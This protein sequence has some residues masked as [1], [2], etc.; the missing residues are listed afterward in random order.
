LAS[1]SYDSEIPGH[2]GAAMTLRT[3]VSAV[4]DQPVVLDTTGETSIFG[5]TFGS[6]NSLPVTFTP[7]A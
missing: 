3:E 7:V 5:V 4:G 6:P 1:F 2:E